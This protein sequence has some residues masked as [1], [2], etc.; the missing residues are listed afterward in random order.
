MV[1]IWGPRA[2]DVV[3]ALTDDDVSNDAFPFA[4]CRTIDLDSIRALAARISYVGELG[5]EVYAPMEQGARLWDLL[6]QAG[7]AHGI[8][9]VGL[10]AYG[11]TLRMEKSYRLMGHELE[12]DR[13]LVE[14]G[15]A[16]PHVKSADFV[17]KA[18]YL[19]Q[20]AAPPTALLC[21]LT[22]DG[23]GADG[24]QRFMLGGEPITLSDGRPLVDRRGR[25]SFTTS[26]G[27][28]PSVGKH[29][30]MAYL[31]LDGA[32]LGSKL[33]V[34]YFGERY[35]VTVAAVGATPLFDPDNT[36]LRS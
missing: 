36:R 12:L 35:P 22:L 25:R 33:A 8:V 29:M 15:M 3:Q 11:T 4:A 26:A 10:G 32:V 31:P 13:N 1:A 28:G 2:R 20:R 7:Q 9:A 16:R 34:E 19:E 6:W 5:W 21:T 18:A 23:D 17:G 27:S 30:L 14:A 24:A